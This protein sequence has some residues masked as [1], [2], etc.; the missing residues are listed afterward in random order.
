MNV[1][2]TA[3][4]SVDLT[5]TV[6]C[7]NEEAFIADTLA[8]VDQAARSAGLNYEIIVI[9]DVSRDRS[10]SRIRD[11]LRAHADEPITLVENKTK[12]YCESCHEQADARRRCRAA[13]RHDLYFQARGLRGPGRADVLSGHD[14]RQK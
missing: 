2:A 6:T 13:A 4:V 11:Y 9:D 7:Y 5:V 8:T 1:S 14:C 3:R 12:A 10:V